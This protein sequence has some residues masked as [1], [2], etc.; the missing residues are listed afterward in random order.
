MFK[1]ALELLAFIIKV[2]TCTTGNKARE[3]MF[4]QLP[5]PFLAVW[6]KKPKSNTVS[7]LGGCEM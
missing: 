3:G 6:T 1:H 4:V 7:C 5:N 2:V